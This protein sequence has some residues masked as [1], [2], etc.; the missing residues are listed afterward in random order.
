M[1]ID[2]L[3]R[4]SRR[5]ANTAAFSMSLGP[6]SR[7]SGTPR[8]S[9]SANFHPGVWLSSAS[10]FTRMPAAFNS[11]AISSHLGSTVSFQVP[12]G[13][14]TI[15][16]WKGAM[17]GGRI[18]PLSSPCVMITPPIRRVDT[19]HDV[20]HACCSVLS[21][22]WN[23]I[24][25]ALAKFCPRLC[26][27]PA[28][29]RTAVAHQRFDRVGLRRAGKL[30]AVALLAVNHRHGKDVLGELLVDAENLH[31]LFLRFVGGFVGGVAFL[32]E[33]L[34]RAQERPRDFL[35]ADDVRPLVDQHGQIAPRLNP[36]LVHHAEDRLGGRPD[37]QLLLELFPAAMRHV[38]DLGRKALDVLGFLEQQA[39]GNQQ[40][41]IRVHMAGGL[42][43]LVELLLDQFPNGVAVRP[44][45]HEALDRRVVGQFGLAD[46]I[47]VPL[48]EV[49]RLL[50][51]FGYE[52]FVLFRFHGH[53]FPGFFRRYGP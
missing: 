40:R 39:L 23:W 27:V 44:N 25:K 2:A 11:A 52:R 42:E 41:E 51:D 18:K 35:P 53:G 17:A 45:D 29:K 28:C 21:R 24:S 20:V 3:T 46:D 50:G 5:A 4:V 12:R 14:G 19:P 16:T 26:E 34:G 31:R 48:G 32:P 47:E 37:D 8:I 49:D 6:I 22:P 9:Y 7:R 38:G 13:I 1:G 15:T 30:L 33:K 36:F 10:S 43:A